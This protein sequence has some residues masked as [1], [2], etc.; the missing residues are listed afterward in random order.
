MPESRSLGGITNWP[1]AV[2]LVCCLIGLTSRIASGDTFRYRNS[3]GDVTELEARLAGSG[4]GV[5]ALEQA[6]GQIELVSEAAVLR[7]TPGD[8]PEPLTG[9]AVLEQLQTRFGEQRFRGML[10]GPY[11]VGVVLASELDRSEERRVRSFLRKGGRFMRNVESVFEDFARS[12]HLELHDPRYPLVVLIFETDDEFEQYTR[13]ATG[14]RGISATNIAGFYSALTN[15]LAIRM[16]ECHTFE[17]PLHEAIHQQVSNRGVARRLA[18]VPKWFHEGIATGF[19]GNGEKI[20]I[21]P[22]RIN[23][24]YA[25]RSATAGRIGWADLV[26]EDSAFGGDILAGD[27]Y[28]HAWGLHWRLVTGYRDAYTQY[29]RHLGELEP[30]AEVSASQRQQDFREA[31]GKDGAAMQA[32]FQPQLELG[33]KRQKVSLAPE[34]PPGVSVTQSALAQVQLTA[35]ML[36]TGILQAEGSLQNISPVREMTYH[37]AVVTDSGTYAEWLIPRLGLR[38]KVSLPRRPAVQVVPGA[39]GGLSRSFRVRVWSTLPDSQEASDWAGGRTRLNS[40]G[41]RR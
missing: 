14:G 33:L 20:S 26:R 37:V 21:G 9:K 36:P 1:A 12:M 3:D 29:V 22:N 8:D 24:H 6:D 17:V 27:A 40:R 39:P 23:S 13:E 38:K 30:L 4:Q 41:T 5:F 25:R 15:W 19:E 11:V 32:E 16:S 31:F 35:V 10:S 2:L 7:R 18:P 28:T 34:H